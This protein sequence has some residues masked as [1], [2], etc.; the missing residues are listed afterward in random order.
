MLTKLT[1]LAECKIYVSIANIKRQQIL[2]SSL[3]TEVYN[4]KI[5]KI[6]SILG[7]IILN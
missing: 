3:G 5:S 1:D 2:Y 4:S 6:L 7:L